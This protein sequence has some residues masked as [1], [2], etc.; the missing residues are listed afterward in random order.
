MRTKL[1]L[2]LI[3]VLLAPWGAQATN[4]AAIVY[5]VPFYT[6]APQG[7]WSDRVFRDA[8]E[9]SSVLMVMSWI[10]GQ[11][12]TP[13]QT[14]AEFHAV[15]A[16]ER[17]NFG[18]HEDTSALETAR[19]FSGYYGLPVELRY[20]IGT[21]EIIASLQERSVVLVPINGQVL[22]N[23]R[24]SPPRHMIVVGGYDSATNQFIIHDPTKKSGNLRV[25]N[26]TLARSLRD[27]P[28][29][30]HKRVTNNKTAMIK[31]G[32]PWLSQ[33]Q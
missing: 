3:L 25:A 18:F 24:R 17:A 15:A 11:S 12:Y 26:D 32:W 21:A 4:S 27:Y 5:D 22:Y 9:E 30:I 20:D 13:A 8:C 23:N 10:N 28:S 33:P 19:I 14:A 6:Q 2:F 31:I 7:K 16:W 1:L 29:G